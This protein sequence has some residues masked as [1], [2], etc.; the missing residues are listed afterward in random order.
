MEMLERAASA[1][2]QLEH[3]GPIPLCI[4]GLFDELA[5][6]HRQAVAG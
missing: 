5:R 2:R 6:M 3:H 4:E 1:E